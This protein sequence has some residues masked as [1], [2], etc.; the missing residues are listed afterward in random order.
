MLE[1]N[2]VL[3]LVGAR[4][5]FGNKPFVVHICKAQVKEIEALLV[6]VLCR[7]FVFT[8]PCKRLLTRLGACSN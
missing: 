5:P 2:S 1:I 7:M 8:Q 4:R 3:L 6:H